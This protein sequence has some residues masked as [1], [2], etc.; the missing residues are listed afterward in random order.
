MTMLQSLAADLAGVDLEFHAFD[1]VGV[2]VAEDAVEQY[3][4]MAGAMPSVPELLRALYDK[5]YHW[6]ESDGN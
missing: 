6:G 3:R 5:K 2:A 4:R 1:E